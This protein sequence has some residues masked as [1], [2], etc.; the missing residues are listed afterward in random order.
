MRLYHSRAQLNARRRSAIGS[1][2][3]PRMLTSRLHL[4]VE[5]FAGSGHLSAALAPAG[6][7]V[8]MWDVELS[9]SHD[10][11]IAH[12]RLCLMRTL[13]AC[14]F[15]HFGIPCVT[16]SAAR[17]GSIGPLLHRRALEVGSA[18]RLFP[19]E[20]VEMAQWAS[21]ASTAAGLDVLQPVLYQLRHAGASIDVA[22]RLR[23]LEE[24]RARGRWAAATSMMRYEKHAQVGKTWHALPPAVQAHALKCEKR[25]ANVLSGALEPQPL[26]RKS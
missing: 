15:S 4:A 6:F 24:I 2:S 9:G 3:V 8:I 17:R 7:Q 23:S 12:N 16:Y 25:L 13:G 5:V 21:Q 20:Y 18:E 22:S 10:L 1:G 11:L 19:F 14:Q 26:I